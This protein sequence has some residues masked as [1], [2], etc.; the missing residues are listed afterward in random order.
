MISSSWRSLSLVACVA[1][2][3]AGCGLSSSTSSSMKGRSWSS[4]GTEPKPGITVGE[5]N[6]IT[7][8]QNG[9]PQTV[10]FWADATDCLSGMKSSSGNSGGMFQM[11]LTAADGVS[12]IE[13]DLDA[14]GVATVAI[15]DQQYS[16]AAGNVFLLKTSGDALEVRQ[17]QIDADWMGLEDY[18]PLAEDSDE[19]Q[20]FFL[21]AVIDADSSQD[22]DAA[23][24]NTD[25]ESPAQTPESASGSASGSN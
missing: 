4:G 1:F 17:L 22:G 21:G 7:L 23:V 8:S 16:L 3:A 24:E 14:Q 5:V 25:G 20:T 15:G 13:V 9:V 6:V 18:Q 12:D 2:V 11:S 10:V 19:L